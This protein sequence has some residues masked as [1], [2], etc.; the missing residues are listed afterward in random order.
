MNKQYYVSFE[1][2]KIGKLLF[3]GEIDTTWY[4]DYQSAK[5]F[6]KPELKRSFSAIKRQYKDK[7]LHIKKI[8]IK[9]EE[10]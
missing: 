2:K 8:N 7:K 5:A 9:E 3:L 4:S 10:L 1:D 6:S